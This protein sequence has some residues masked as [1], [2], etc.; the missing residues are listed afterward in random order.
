[1]HK[2]IGPDEVHPR[3]LRELAHEVAKPLSTISEKLWQ[4]GEVPSDWKRGNITPMFRKG[5]K[6]DPG[7]YRPVSL[8]SE[9]SNNMEQIRL[10]TMLRLMENKEVTGNSQH[11]FT[12]GKLCLMNLVAFYGAVT[13]LVAKGRETDVIYLD[14]SKALTP[15]CTTSLSLNWRE[16]DLTDGPL[17]G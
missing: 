12:K 6:E 7:N 9:P 8:S 16:I 17:G 15:S 2:S 3:V 1:V 4:S 10:E 5:K 11:G 13:S 14:L